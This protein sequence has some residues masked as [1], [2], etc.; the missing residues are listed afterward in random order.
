MLISEL[1][2]L[3]ENYKDTDS[4]IVALWDKECFKA[5][6][7]EARIVTDKEW[8]YVAENFSVQMH[9]Q[10]LGASIRGV[11]ENKMKEH[12][13]IINNKDNDEVMLALEEIYLEQWI[14]ENRGNAKDLKQ[15]Y[16]ATRELAA[17]VN[18]LETNHQ[19]LLED[20][21]QNTTDYLKHLKQAHL[22]DHLLRPEKISKMN[23]GTFV[24]E[25]QL[26]LWGS[27]VYLFG[28][29]TNYPPFFLGKFI[30][31]K[32]IKQNEFFASVYLHVAMIV[33]VIYF[34]VQLLTVALV[35][36]NWGLLGGYA[37]SVIILGYFCLWFYPIRQKI[38][39]RWRLLRMVRKQ[40]A[41]IESFVHQRSEIIVL[42]EEARGC[43]KE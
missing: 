9:D 5:L 7:T 20:L 15:Q 27:I 41:D 37:L 8:D 4:V 23:F 39:G 26:I 36:R 34:G 33:W 22:R 30:A 14:N 21:K 32:K 1:K 19:P 42:I 12:L 18:F 17:M 28:L 25:S 24:L 16:T 2:E 3:I 10:M 13:V 11:L 29:L 40:R 31:N 38:F 6:D 43:F 35:F